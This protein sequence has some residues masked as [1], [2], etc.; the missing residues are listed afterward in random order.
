MDIYERMKTYYENAGRIYLTRRLPVIIR[1]DGKTFH[2]L[3]KKCQRPF[4]EDFRIAMEKTAIKLCE[5]V[6]NVRFAY[7][8]SDEISLLLTDYQNLDTSQWFDGNI[9]KMVSV[10]ASIAGVEFSKH[11][12][13]DAYFDSRVFV[14]PKE[15]VTNYFIWRQWDAS[16]NSI[17]MVGQAN[18]SHKELFRLNTNEIQEKMFKEKGI[19]WDTYPTKYKR[20]VG[21]YKINEAVLKG[22]AIAA[23]R[24]NWTTDLELPMFSKEKEYIEKFI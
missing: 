7:I 17:Q 9:Q 20:G 2:S 22:L 12:G 16:N 24:T 1:L 3:T 4:D 21:I 5:E 8:Q 15:E 19:N 10:S 13:K 14:I 11:F 23:F 6:Q 18:F